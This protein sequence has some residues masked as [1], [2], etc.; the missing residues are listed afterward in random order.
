MSAADSAV[1]D[2]HQPGRFKSVTLEHL[3][4]SQAELDRVDA[5]F[6]RLEQRPEVQAMRAAFIGANDI[7]TL[8]HTERNVRLFL[9]A[10]RALGFDD[11][12]LIDRAI[13][14][15]AHD[16]GKLYMPALIY[17]KQKWT[18]DQRQF[19]KKHPALSLQKLE[20]LGIVLSPQAR[21]MAANHHMYKTDDPYG[22]PDAVAEVEQDIEAQQLLALVDTYEAIMSD[23]PHVEH[24]AF[25]TPAQAM[26]M[27]E[28]EQR[29]ISNPRISMA[30]RS[31]VVP[32]AA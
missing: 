16:L 18:D 3:N 19:A 20:E 6:A 31:V 27:A 12:R 4:A 15:W 10:G 11:K 29:G 14:V 8:N 22:A 28:A 30:L 23:R 1:E 26:V 24:E 17:E 2:L 32:L 5:L 21:G 13:G 9:H 7:F 25:P